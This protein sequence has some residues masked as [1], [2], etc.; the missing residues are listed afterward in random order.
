MAQ[1]YRYKAVNLQGQKVEGTIAA[2]SIDDAKAQLFARALAPVSVSAASS[3]SKKADKRPAKKGE[4]IPLRTHL[5]GLLSARVSTADLVLFTKQLRTLYV[6]GISLAE[7]FTIL[8]QQLESKPLRKVCAAIE[9]RIHAGESLRSAFAAHPKVFN[10]LYV[11]MIEAGER[12]GA[13][14]R[15]LERLVFMLEHEDRIKTQIAAA[16]RYPKMLVATM[17]GA[18]LV[19]LNYVVPQFAAVYASARVA[20]PWPTVVAIEMNRFLSDYW[21]IA[22]SATVALVVGARMWL[23][24]DRGRFL[25]DKWTMRIPVVGPLVQKSVMARFAAIFS[26]LQQS[27]VTIIEAMDVLTETVDNA[28][29]AAQFEEVKER[30]RAG[31]GIA[32]SIGAVEGFSPLAVQL[33]SVGEKASHLE[34]MM[35]VLSRHYDEEVRLQ[36]DKLTEYLGPALILCL[37]VVVLFFALAIFLPMW[38]MVKFVK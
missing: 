36:V 33:L 31:G 15:V 21:W 13:L 20:L 26:I 3:S 14:P 22:I 24:T 2:E 23:K 5:V 30:L 8:A 19:L 6:A 7:I 16:L 1:D 34:E 25:K 32:D 37:G 29:F 18:F 12:S 9:E 27:G 28:F 4:E 17:L 10:H 38:D 11:A 35:D